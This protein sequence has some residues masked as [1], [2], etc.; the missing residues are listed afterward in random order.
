MHFPSR[1]PLSVCSRLLVA[2]VAIA[3][4]AGCATRRPAP[5]DD[6][7]LARGQAPGATTAARAVPGGTAEAPPVSTYTVKRGDTL[8]QIA[9]DNGLDYRELAAWN[10][11]E[12]VNRILPGQVLRLAPPGEPAAAI[13]STPA[14]ADGATGVTTAPLRTPPPVLESAPGT[15]PQG[16]VVLPP[17]GPAMPPPALRANEANA[18]SIAGAAF[19]AAKALA[20]AVWSAP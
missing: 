19:G 6:R 14:A 11:I 1:F 12:N 15:T 9:L 13:A 7:T 17:Q 4:V 8:H 16:A 5:V 10:G 3:L 2:I 20:S 18:L